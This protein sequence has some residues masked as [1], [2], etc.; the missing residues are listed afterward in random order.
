MK[1][2]LPNLGDLLDQA[3]NR[4]ELWSWD[5]IIPAND[6]TLI[7]AFMKK[8]KTTLLSGYVNAVLR[9]GFYCGLGTARAKRVLYLAPEEGDTLLRKLGRLGFDAQDGVHL[10]VIPRGHSLWATLVAQYRTRNWPGVVA[11]LKSAGYDHVVLDGLH[12]MLQMFEPQAKEDNEGVGKFMANFVLPF[13][14]DF[15]V[16]ASLH[17]KKA[18]GDPRV[19]IP[20]EEMIRG[21]SAWMAHPGQILVLEHDRKADLKTMHCFGRYETSKAQGFAL[22]YDEKKHD[23]VALVDDGTD[24][25]GA[26]AAG[27]SQ[28]AILRAKVLHVLSSAQASLSLKT[29]QSL[30]TARRENIAFALGELE[31][32]G[33]VKRITTKAQNGRKTEQ[34]ELV[35]SIDPGV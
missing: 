9:T 13:G 27:A 15:T 21:A 20:P 7:A 3:K 29:I 4:K 11:A 25:P 19:H 26:L 12:T 32:M 14:S 30:V 34:W 22:R 5:G 2:D 6:V 23:Y 8:G 33:S 31:K 1:L 28:D 24:D 17:T 16:V 10:T 18:G 35:S